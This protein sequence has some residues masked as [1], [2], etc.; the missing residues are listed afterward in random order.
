MGRWTARD[1][2]LNRDVALKVL[3]GHLRGDLD[4]LARFTREA[5][6]LAALNHPHIATIH[7]LENQDGVAALALQLVEGPTLAGRIARG[8]VPVAEALSIARQVA[9][10]LEA[11]HDK[12]ILHRDLKPS[13]IGLT[14][15]GRVKV[16]DFG[17]AKVLEPTSD[18]AD[19]ATALHTRTG[20]V[21]GTPGT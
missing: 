14:R 17:L 9:E 7:G 8:P 11:A 6:T 10:A 1:T 5:Q 13:N 18:A 16:L 12:G 15:D 20:L 21:M 19:T 3:P 4:R 2:R